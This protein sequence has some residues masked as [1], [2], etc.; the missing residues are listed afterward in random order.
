MANFVGIQL[1]A[2]HFSEIRVLFGLLTHQ[3]AGAR[4]SDRNLALPFRTA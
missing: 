2:V 1:L 4:R 3:I